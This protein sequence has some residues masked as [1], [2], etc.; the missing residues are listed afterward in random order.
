MDI[1]AI[2]AERNIREAMARGHSPRNPLLKYL[3]VPFNPYRGH[4]TANR[5]HTV[6]QTEKKSIL[7]VCFC[8]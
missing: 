8:E 2:I 3:K 7:R 4:S 5:P 6:G 1:L